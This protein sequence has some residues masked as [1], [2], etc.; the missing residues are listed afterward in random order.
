[1]IRRPPRSTPTDTL[2]PY[3]TLYRSEK[4]ERII[5]SIDPEYLKQVSTASTD[6][7]RCFHF[8]GTEFPH[9]LHLSPEEQ[10]RFL[11]YRS[12]AHTFE[13][14]SLLFI[15]YDVF[16]LKNIKHSIYLTLHINNVILA[17]IYDVT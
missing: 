7:D 10:R 16:C 9:R 15:S 12:E 4:H 17:I 6:L 5:V 14:Q 11:Y 1:M 3:T 2:F 13:L 8:R